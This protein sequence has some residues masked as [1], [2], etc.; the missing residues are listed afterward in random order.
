MLTDSTIVGLKPVPKQRLDVWDE[1][2]KVPGFGIRVSPNGKKTWTLVY[3]FQGAPRR[4]SLGRYPVI[5]LST[6]R[7]HARK[8]LAAIVNGTDPALEKKERQAA[9]VAK[10]RQD[11]DGAFGKIAER[12]IAEYAKPNNRERTWKHD[13]WI[14]KKHVLPFWKAKP[15]RE[16]TR[17]DV[18]ALLQRPIER[19]GNGAVASGGYVSNRIRACLSKLFAWAI[20]EDLCDHN[21]IRDV[22]R[23][24]K[25]RPS[26]RVLSSEEIRTLWQK[27]DSLDG[28][29]QAFFK[30][31]LLTGARPGE[32]RGATWS[33]IDFDGAVWSL[34]SDRTK[35]HQPRRIPLSPTAGKVLRER[36]AA[37]GES[38][39][40]F[41]GEGAISGVAILTSIKFGASALREACGFEFAPR[42]I[43][44]TVATNIASMGVRREVVR[45]ILGHVDSSVTGRHYDKYSYEPEARAALDKWDR[46]LTKIVTGQ[47]AKVVKFPARA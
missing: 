6:A 33:E 23:L 26:D 1:N 34:P 36:K 10:R 14:L 2:P 25:E 22:K 18:K 39:F 13:D 32:V 15:V 43:R 42:D 17:A 31:A 40:V 45:A 47:T 4:L 24:G 20:E 8:A 19:D 28:R 37:A 44:R 46:A 5:T 30:L 7:D 29:A 9:S 38:S 41:S 3:R 35:T 27:L 21:V 11:Q 16:I 12:F